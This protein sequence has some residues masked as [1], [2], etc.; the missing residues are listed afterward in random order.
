VLELFERC[1]FVDKTGSDRGGP[2]AAK[3]ATF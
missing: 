1:F 2:H 3:L